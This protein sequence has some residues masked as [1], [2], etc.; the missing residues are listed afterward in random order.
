MLRTADGTFLEY[1]GVK[2]VPIQI[3]TLALEVAFVVTN[4]KRII[5]SAGLLAMKDDVTTITSK[6]RPRLVHKHGEVELTRF[7]ALLFLKNSRP[8]SEV[9]VAGVDEPGEEENLKEQHDFDAVVLPSP[10]KPHEAAV[11]SHR[12]THIP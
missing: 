8:Y 2:R 12:A 3:G 10:T 11:E 5:V 9:N 6:H 7:G 1:H 4:A